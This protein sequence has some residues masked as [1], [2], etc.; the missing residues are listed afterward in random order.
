MIISLLSRFLMLPAQWR[1]PWWLIKTHS[2]KTCSPRVTATSWTME[3]TIRYLSGKV[4]DHDIY[5]FLPPLVLCIHFMLSSLITAGCNL[6]V[7]TLW[8]LSNWENMTHSLILP[9]FE[10]SNYCTTPQTAGRDANAD[11]RKAAFTAANKF[12]KDKNYPNNTQVMWPCS[13][14]LLPV[15]HP[16]CL[17]LLYMNMLALLSISDMI[18]ST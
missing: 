16:S 11:E 10:V 17:V 7:S 3:E 2:N 1:Q 8:F 4:L 18:R 12:I 13:E 9:E 5:P 15:L 14:S 6:L